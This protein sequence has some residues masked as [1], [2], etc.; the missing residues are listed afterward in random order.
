MVLQSGDWLIVFTDGL[1]EAENKLAQEFGEQ[2]L[3]DILQLDSTISSSELLSKI[4]ASLDAFVGETP[5]HDDVTC[6]VIYGV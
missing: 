6:M 1:V 5:Q 2:R 4:M 3:L